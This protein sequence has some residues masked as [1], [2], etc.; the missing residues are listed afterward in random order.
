MQIIQ[1]LEQFRI[2]VSWCIAQYIQTVMRLYRSIYLVVKDILD[3]REN[4]ATEMELL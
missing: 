4:T 3:R 1:T 2:R